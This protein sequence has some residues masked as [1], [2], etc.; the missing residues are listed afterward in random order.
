MSKKVLVVEDDK[1]IRQVLGDALHTLGIRVGFAT[2]GQEA[3][4]YL[5]AEEPPC[6]ILLDLMMPVMDGWKFRELQQASPDLA[7][8]PVVVVT[9]DGH[10]QQKAAQ[11]GV[12]FGIAKPF[13]MAD[14]MRVKAMYC[15]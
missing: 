7:K 9:A 2:N 1:D 8:I 12:S 15:G 6:V 3:L 14:L 11:M 5:R 10:A 13:E 4:D